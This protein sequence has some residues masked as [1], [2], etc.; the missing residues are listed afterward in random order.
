[1]HIYLRRFLA[2][3]KSFGAVSR[4]NARR[5]PPLFFFLSLLFPP[6]SDNATTRNE[7]RLPLALLI[8]GGIALTKSLSGTDFGELLK[9]GGRGGE[10]G[11]L[12]LHY[13]PAPCL[14]LRTGTI[15]A[16][17]PIAV[18]QKRA[19]LLKSGS[20]TFQGKLQRGPGTEADFDALGL[21]LRLYFRPPDTVKMPTIY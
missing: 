6:P 5:L 8:R 3:S 10:K 18:L 15:A 11:C 4:A 12:M 20:I 9:E 21:Y 1:M 17:A 7:P 19:A 16:R 13:R 2:S 14:A